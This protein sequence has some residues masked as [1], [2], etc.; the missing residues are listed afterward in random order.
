MTSRQPFQMELPKS[1]SDYRPLIASWLPLPAAERAE[2]YRW[3]GRNDLY[4]LGR[5]LLHRERLEHP[6]LF[7]R[8]REVQAEPNGYLDLWGR[9]HYKS[10]IITQIL[11]IQDILNDPEVT[12]GFFSNVRPLAKSF[13][14]LIKREFE[15]NEALKGLYPD[16]LWD[17]PTKQA[18][19]WSE[20]EGIVVKRKGN[21]PESTIEAWGLIEGLPTGK[22]FKK[23]VYDDTVTEESVNT[24][25]QM[26]K[27]T[28]QWSYSLAL[29][30]E[31][32]VDRV[33]GT[34]YHAND[35][36]HE[37]IRRGAVKVR[38]YPATDDGTETGKAVFLPDETLRTMRRD[39][40][41]WVFGSQMLLN[42]AADKVQGFKKEWLR[43]RDVGESWRGM[44][45]YI[46]VD[47][48]GAKQKTSDYTVFIVIGLGG[49]H[50]YQVLKIIRDRL[51]LTE[52]TNMLFKLHRK[53]RPLKV[54]YESYGKDSDIEHMKYV[55]Q[56]ENYDFENDIVGL[57]GPMPK[58]QRIRR[59]VPIFESGRMFLP[60]GSEF[61]NHEQIIVDGVKALVDD[62]YSE[63]PVATHDDIL[64][65]LARI[66]DPDLDV[67]W[68]EFIVEDEKPKW[69]KDLDLDMESE[70]VGF[71]GR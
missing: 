32:V 5:Y 49:D 56:V 3:F 4:F 61:V 33:V 7:D 51:N 42:P 12:F 19:K 52:R 41:V 45:R 11:T 15:T 54:G 40:G 44:N 25:E 23:R 43:Y 57:G 70:D 37:M 63:F 64:D 62:E 69:M 24:P 6:W 39:M 60:N 35:T 34:F 8:C 59:L 36:Y 10:S 58:P 18:P 46:L 16:V 9:F 53:Y 17:D 65:A 28:Q 67:T 13:L 55:M 26:A 38:K 27:T 14:R 48:A 2:V 30:A 31:E 66:V 71:M 1:P 47:P 21:P 20:D 29:R 50:R 22:H 68:P